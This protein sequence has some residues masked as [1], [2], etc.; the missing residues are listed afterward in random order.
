VYL[1]GGLDAK[2]ATFGKLVAK[3]PARRAPLALTRLL[4]LYVA[5]GAGRGA[6]FWKDVAPDRIK[7]TLGELVDLADADAKDE[8]FIDLGETSAFEVVQGEGECAA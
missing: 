7:A 2:G 6:S 1:G 5:E 4:E 3:V 8:D